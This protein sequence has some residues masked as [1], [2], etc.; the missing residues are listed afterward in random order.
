MATVKSD[1][2]AK[3]QTTKDGDIEETQFK[4]GDEV[5][6]VQTWDQFVLIRDAHGHFY[7]V[8]KDKIEP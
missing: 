4:R 2:A 7:N 3:F 5:S 8:P 6:L 1:F